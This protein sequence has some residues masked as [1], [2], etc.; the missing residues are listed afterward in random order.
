[1]FAEWDD[2]ETPTIFRLDKYYKSK[3]R[4]RENCTFIEAVEQIKKNRHATEFFEYEIVPICFSGM[5]GKY[6]RIWKGGEWS[7]LDD[8]EILMKQI[9]FC[10][11]KHDGQNIEYVY[12]TDKQYLYW[13][14]KERPHKMLFLDEIVRLLGEMKAKGFL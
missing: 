3:K 10:G 9:E 2:Y 5:G 13:I 12:K 8:T 14:L 4:H 11:G 1:M 7:E 6:M